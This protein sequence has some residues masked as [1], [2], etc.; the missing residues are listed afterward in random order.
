VD[1]GCN[2]QC[3]RYDQVYIG[4]RM[5]GDESLEHHPRRLEAPMRVGHIK[6][7]AFVGRAVIIRRC[8]IVTGETL[9]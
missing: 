7:R 3:Y 8:V 1:T 5:S 4:D 2:S 6:V 9:T